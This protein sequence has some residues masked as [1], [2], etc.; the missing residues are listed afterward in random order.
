MDGS[1]GSCGNRSLRQYIFEGAGREHWRL[2][3]AGVFVENSI[4]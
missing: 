3:V 2:T 4:Y 1:S